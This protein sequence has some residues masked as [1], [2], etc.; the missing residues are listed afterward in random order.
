M[1]GCNLP[2]YKGL[3]LIW[4]AGLCLGTSR[5]PAQEIATETELADQVVA[6]IASLPSDPD[7]PLAWENTAVYDRSAGLDDLQ[8]NF[9]TRIR[10]ALHTGQP[11]AL[12][13]V[14]DQ[15]PAF[16]AV[17]GD[18]TRFWLAYGLAAAGR[19]Q[20]SLEPIRELLGNPLALTGLG[21]GQRTW[22]V[23]AAADQNFLAGNTAQARS[24]YEVMA[25]SGRPFLMRWGTYQLAGLDFVAFAYEASAAG[26][27]TV[28]SSGADDIMT[29]QAC[30]M[31]DMAELLAQFRREGEPYGAAK[32]FAP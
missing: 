11:A 10:A 23:T 29:D 1:S 18:V 30:S 21:A 7:L 12:E 20:E 16:S 24:L 22:L 5:S 26:Y 6:L 31:A 27:R 3:V 28:C 2:F 32:Y 13:T 14:L 4:C 8:A 9:I 19:P 25:R 15:T 17:T